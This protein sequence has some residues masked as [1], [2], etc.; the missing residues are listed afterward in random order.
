MANRRTTFG[1]LQR[2]RDKKAKALEK[3]EKRAAR[4]EEP[5]QE[6]EVKAADQDAVL[7][8]LAELHERFDAGAVAPSVVYCSVSGLGQDGPLALTPGHD[9]NYQAWAGSLAPDGGAPVVPAIPVAD[10]AGGM[11]AAL[12]VCAALVWR[13]RTGE[14]ERVDV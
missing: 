8:A 3:A 4:A 13:I 5:P 11:A 7:A 6:P 9:L 10:L 12:G 14:G 2:E 1:K